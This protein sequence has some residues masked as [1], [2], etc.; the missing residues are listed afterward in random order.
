VS[1]CCYGFSGKPLWRPFDM[2]ISILDVSRRLGSDV[3]D[4]ITIEKQF[5]KP[6]GTIEGLCGVTKLHRML[7]EENLAVLSAEAC[8]DVVQ[9]CGIS[10]DQISGVFTSCNPTTDYLIPSLAPLV[11]KELG[12]SHILAINIGMGCAGGIQALQAAHNQL[13]ADT[14]AEQVRYYLVVAGDHTSRMLDK[15][16]WKTAIMF[17]DGVTAALVTNDPNA[18]G[19]L[20]IL[21][22]NSE[23]YAG[24]SVCVINLPNTLA[25]D[26]T[27]KHFLG[28]RGRG[29]F[30]FGTR[31][32][33]RVKKLAG[34]SD[35]SN[36]YIIPHQANIRMLS[37]LSPTLGVDPEQI[38]TK[39]ITTVGNISG[40]A[41]FLGLE[42]V[43]AD[44]AVAGNRDDI[45]LCAF[46]A[47]L[48]VAV[49][50]LK[51]RA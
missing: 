15:S 17:S 21:R 9:R 13:L 16:A 23:T 38:Y 28:M 50:V 30:E 36:F 32:A 49:S 12:L 26:G 10:L 7:P 31:I 37:E 45:L 4:P 48:Q 3:I 27:E 6:A 35:L 41:C 39:G 14:L 24:E 42:E 2:P 19:G 1:V 34:V 5:D 43:I 25:T 40:A 46:G 11:V 18:T 8:R 33:P 22:T 47:E 29:V 51:R 20:E 44:S